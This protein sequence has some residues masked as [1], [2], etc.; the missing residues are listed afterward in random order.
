MPTMTATVGSAVGLHAR[1]AML[2]AQAAADFDEEVLLHI[3]GSDPE[4]AVDAT[5]S[6][7]IMTLG[8]ERGDLVV[9]TSEDEAAVARIADLIEQDLDA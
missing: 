1:P 7:M 9:V 5:S 6:L 3:E 8:A 2:I 4:D